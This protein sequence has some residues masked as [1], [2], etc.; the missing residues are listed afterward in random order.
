MP[1]PEWLVWLAVASLV[2]G[3]LSAVWIALDVTAHRQQMWIMNVVWPITGLYAGPLAVAAYYRWGRQ[4][5]H[6]AMRAAKD[7]GEEPAMQ[8]RPMAV[9]IGL[10]ATHCGSGCTLAD[11]VAEWFLFFVPAVAAWGA[12]LL[13]RKIFF[14]W[15]LDYVVA[16]AFG[17][18]FQYFTIV[19]MRNLSPGKGLIQAAKADVASLTA[20]QLGMYGWMALAT[21]VIFGRELPRTDPVFWLMMQLA[22]LCGFITSYPVV[23][24]L[25]ASGVKEKM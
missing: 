9:S 14:A 7:R 1:H 2:V 18:A 3:G 8:R 24:W 11:V 5:T 21:F 17:I 20:W 4:G 13:G 10:G 6:A 23:W 15:A 16:L 25:V 22:M 19:P 12:G